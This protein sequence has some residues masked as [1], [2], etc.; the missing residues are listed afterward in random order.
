MNNKKSRSPITTHVLDLTTGKAAPG[1]LVELDF[2]KRF[3]WKKLG[4]GKTNA[5][6]R[7]ENFL[8]PG[9]SIEAGDYRL[10]FNV[11]KYKGKKAFFPEVNLLFRINEVKRHYHVPLL[12]SEFGYSTYRGT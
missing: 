5:D 6:G 2:K 11:E 10:R 12:L 3:G 7:I 1:I 4:S 9:A 8:S